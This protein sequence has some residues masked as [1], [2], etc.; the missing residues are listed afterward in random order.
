[1]LEWFA[2][3]LGELVLK[4]K[5]SLVTLRGISEF[6]EDYPLDEILLKAIKGSEGVYPFGELATYGAAL[7]GATVHRKGYP[8]FLTMDDLVLTPPAFTPKRLEKM[9]ELLR[10]PVFTDVNLE[11]SIGGL[12]SSMPLVVGTMGSTDI[13]SRYSLVIARAAAKEG[14]PYGIGENVHTIRGYDR[15]LTRGHPSFKERVMAYLTNIDKY[16]GVIIQQNVEDAYDEH[17]NKVYSDKDLE[18]Y[19]DEGRVAFEIKVGQ[20][21]KPGLGGVI[22]MRKEEAVKVKEKYHFLEDPA[23]ARTAWVERYSAP[24]T[25]TADILRGMIR[26]MKTSYPRAKVWIK[27]G[28]F[29]DVLEV[30]KVSYEEGADAVIIDGKEGGTGMAPS[31]AMKELGYPTV[32]GL[33]KIRKARLMGVDDRMSLLLAGRLFNGAHI[34]K[35][36]ALGATAIYVGRPFIVAAMVKDE[37]GVRNFIEAT[38]VETQMIVSALGKYSIGDVSPEDVASLNRDL[39]SALGVPYVYSGEP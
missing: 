11:T 31:V 37:A 5:G 6:M 21:A 12:K 14:I 30:V 34:V 16:G 23:E 4:V 38:R 18:P 10:E 20:G 24:G 7:L 19:L 27:V 3:K 39:A 32:V 33:A 13:A 1:M 22:K 2:L 8:R 9:A 35:A 29:R 26:L 15:R 17:W 25:Y 36:R 28:P